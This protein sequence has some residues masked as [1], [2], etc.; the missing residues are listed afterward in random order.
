MYTS[1]LLFALSAV[2]N[3]ELIPVAPSWRSDYSLALKEGRSARRPLAIFA[4]P[5]PEGWD[6][7]SK[8]GALDKEAKDLLSQHYVCLYVDTSKASGRR[9]AEQLDL[10]NGRGLVIGDVTGEKQAFWHSGPLRNEDLDY[11]LRK[12]SD[13]ERVIVRTEMVPESPPQAVPTYQPAPPP[14]NY[15]QPSFYA[16][17]FRSFGGC[18]T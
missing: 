13:P 11:Y 4:H 18:S 10:N 16:P 8:E 15:P 14:V 5:G 17:A 9:L 3:A 12:Y 6:N 1:V 7:L 2:P